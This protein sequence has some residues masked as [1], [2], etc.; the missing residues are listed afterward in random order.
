MS[1]TLTPDEYQRQA[2]RT[3]LLGQ[4]P[5]DRLFEAVLGLCG[6]AGEIADI[7]KKTAYQEHKMDKDA[8]LEEAG[9]VC[10]YLALLCD[11]MRWSLSDVMQAN[12]DKLRQRYPDGFDPA[13]SVHREG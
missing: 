9:D 12:V 11:A 6:E 7:V 3:A 10:W 8:L 13:R 5:G 2:M 4:T 1:T